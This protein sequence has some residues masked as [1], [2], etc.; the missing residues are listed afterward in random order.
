M[1]RGG[2][3][4]LAALA[5][6]FRERGPDAMRDASEKPAW[7]RR[8]FE[9]LRIVRLFAVKLVAIRRY[10]D[11]KDVHRVKPEY[12]MDSLTRAVPSAVA[13]RSRRE[14]RRAGCESSRPRRAS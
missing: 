7:R 13:A 9:G 11:E 1:L 4:A 8:P 12:A 14:R 10:R 5:L 2:G 3:V 6:R